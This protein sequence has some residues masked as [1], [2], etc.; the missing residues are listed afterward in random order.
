MLDLKLEEKKPTFFSALQIKM[1]C[2]FYTIHPRM[3]YKLVEEV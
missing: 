1:A 3:V 2:Y